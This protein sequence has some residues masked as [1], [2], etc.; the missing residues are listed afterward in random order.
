MRWRDVQ[1]HAHR[2]APA[3][4]Q[5]ALL[6]NTASLAWGGAKSP[7]PARLHWEQSWVLQGPP[8]PMAFLYWAPLLILL[9]RQLLGAVEKRGR[10]EYEAWFYVQRMQK[11]TMSLAHVRAALAID[12]LTWAQ[13]L[14]RL[15][16]M[17][18][19]PCTF[20]QRREN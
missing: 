7:A 1:A 2:H 20:Y 17:C 15:W 3:W 11:A 8:C 5:Q 12:L 14:Q 10:A 9:I 6:F 19:T 4:L 13:G 16:D 18:W